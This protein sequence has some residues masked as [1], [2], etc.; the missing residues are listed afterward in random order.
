[1]A[2]LHDIS[3]FDSIFIGFL[4]RLQ[5]TLVITAVSL[6]FDFCWVSPQLF[7]CLLIDIFV[8]LF[9][10]TRIT[11]SEVVNT[12]TLTKNCCGSFDNSR[13]C[14]SP[15]PLIS[16]SVRGGGGEIIQL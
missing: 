1:L 8:L 3:L 13:W 5:I 12:T 16:S 2:N 4:R 11:R 6:A 15:I 9:W 7:E 10:S 14:P